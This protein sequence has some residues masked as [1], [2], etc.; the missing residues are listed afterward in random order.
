M[1]ILIT[2]SA[3]FIGS[4]LTIKMLE[5]GHEVIG[6]DNHNDYYSTLLKEDR[7]A[8]HLNHDKYE[9]IRTDIADTKAVMD[10]FKAFSPQIV[11]HLAA[12][13]GVRYSIENPYI[14]IFKLKWLAK[15]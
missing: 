5:L 15:L 2:G 10:I 14:N 4:A 9:H 6:I 7:L 13:A 11:F 12:Q 3:G 8:R 1:K